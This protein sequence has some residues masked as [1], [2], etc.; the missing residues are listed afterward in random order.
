MGED[1]MGVVRAM[2]IVI[3][4]VLLTNQASAKYI[5][6]PGAGTSCGKWLEERQK[7]GVGD[8]QLQGWVLG[9]LSGANVNQQGTDFLVAVDAAAISAWLDNYCRQHPLEMLWEA[10]DSLILDLAKRA[11]SAGTKTK[12]IWGE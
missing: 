9:Y 12:N 4:M 3:S 2:V 10:S 6:G 7:R 1:D 11:A 5:H 8:V